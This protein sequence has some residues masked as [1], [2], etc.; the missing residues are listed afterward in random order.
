MKIIL[1]LA[2]AGVIAWGV[3][4][5]VTAETVIGQSIATNLFVAGAVCLNGGAIVDAIDRKG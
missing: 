4:F 1:L 3:L 5:W 2:G